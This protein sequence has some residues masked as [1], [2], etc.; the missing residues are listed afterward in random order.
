MRRRSAGI[1]VTKYLARCLL[2][3]TYRR[4]R[5]AAGHWS[6]VHSG[7][8]FSYRC[9][10]AVYFCV[11]SFSRS[12]ILAAAVWPIISI[13]RSTR[14]FTLVGARCS[15]HRHCLCR[16]AC[17]ASGFAQVLW[18]RFS[19]GH[20]LISSSAGLYQQAFSDVHSHFLTGGVDT[21]G[22]SSH[23]FVL[24]AFFEAEF[25]WRYQPS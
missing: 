11:T 8:C 9:C 25:S 6:A 19:H 14:T 5:S 13:Y 21:V 12:V 18:N 22:A 16:G 3:C 1:Y 7:S 4:G 15:W 23:N 20:V 2:P 17:L 10:W 24:D